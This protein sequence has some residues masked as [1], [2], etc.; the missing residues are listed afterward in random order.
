M[1][2]AAIFN[3]CSVMKRNQEIFNPSM[4]DILSNSLFLMAA[5]LFT[6]LFCPFVTNEWDTDKCDADLGLACDHICIWQPV[7]Y[8]H[9]LVWPLTWILKSVYLHMHSSPRF[10][11]SWHYGSCWWWQV[12]L[13]LA[14]KFRTHPTS[15]LHNLFFSLRQPSALITVHHEWQGG[16][17]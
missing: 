6:E 1:P 2:V 17:E 9:T 16:L 14:E 13:T 15:C 5:Y 4:N 7:M 3:C 12:H 11:M 8:P 10:W